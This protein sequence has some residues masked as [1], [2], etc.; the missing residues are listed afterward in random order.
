MIEIK[1]QVSRLLGGY[2]L[3]LGVPATLY[4][5]F[6]RQLQQQGVSDHASLLIMP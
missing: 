3:S 6:K 2:W 1:R 4:Q 5:P